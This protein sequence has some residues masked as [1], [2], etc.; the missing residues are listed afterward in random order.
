MLW[1]INCKSEAHVK[2]NKK[3][4]GNRNQLAFA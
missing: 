1:I 2:C 3:I 4:T